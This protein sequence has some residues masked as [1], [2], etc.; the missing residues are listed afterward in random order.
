MRCLIV[1]DSEEF[2]ASVSRLLGSQGLEIVAYALSGEQALELAE[3]L[4]PDL[5]LVDIELGE[6]D[7]FALSH[8][9][10]ARAPSTRIILIS[11]Y[12]PDDMGDLIERSP[13]AGFLPKTDLGVAAITRLLD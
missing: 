1:D 7:G 9:L 10:A 4:K 5:A 6:E 2:V 3:Q 13:A 11:T 8:E 12:G